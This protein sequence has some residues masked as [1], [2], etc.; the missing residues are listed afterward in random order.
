MVYGATLGPFGHPAL[1]GRPE[2]AAM[3]TLRPGL[4]LAVFAP[5]ALVVARALRGHTGRWH[6]ALN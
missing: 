2:Q 6:G 5:M 3:V 4:S 1:R